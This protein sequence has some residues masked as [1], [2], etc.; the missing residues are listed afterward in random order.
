MKPKHVQRGV[1]LGWPEER[2][3]GEGR[4]SGQIV[5]LSTQCVIQLTPVDSEQCLRYIVIIIKKMLQNL[6]SFN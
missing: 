4:S 1:A 3:G 6:I 2:S 5:N